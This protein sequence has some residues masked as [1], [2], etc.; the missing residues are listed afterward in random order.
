MSLF[1]FNDLQIHFLSFVFGHWCENGW[2]SDS[3]I[4]PVWRISAG[5][6]P[7]R[8]TTAVILGYLQAGSEGLWNGPQQM[9]NPRHLG[10]QPGGRRCIMASPFLKR[11]L[12]SRLRQRG[13]PK[14][15]K[16]RELDKWQIVFVFSVE[17]IVTLALA[18]SATLDAVPR[19]LIQ[20][21]LP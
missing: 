18:F 4:S 17:G 6:S 2:W 19:P 5:K 1:T 14:T 8:E 20:S 3:K 9:G 10:V 12:S 11:P 16:I 21:T 13:S 7:Q 15:S